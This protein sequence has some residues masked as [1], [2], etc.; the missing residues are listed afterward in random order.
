MPLHCLIQLCCKPDREGRFITLHK[1]A[2]ILHIMPGDPHL[3]KSCTH[4][5]KLFV[6]PAEF[7]KNNRETGMAPFRISSG[8]EHPTGTV[9]R[10]IIGRNPGHLILVNLK[11]ILSSM[12]KPLRRLKG[13]GNTV[14]RKRVGTDK[15]LLQAVTPSY[16]CLISSLLILYLTAPPR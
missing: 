12:Q 2:A 8:K 16:H 9:K 10:T 7:R 4:P 1:P 6:L 3:I 15:P 14:F 5:D 13:T 11:G